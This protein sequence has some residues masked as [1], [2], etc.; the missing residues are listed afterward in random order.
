MQSVEPSPVSV[1]GDGSLARSASPSSHG[2]DVRPGFKPSRFRGL[3]A[4]KHS[5]LSNL[6]I[7]TVDM[8]K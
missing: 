5:I 8:L 1:P 6:L 3:F 7:N 4:S 2:P